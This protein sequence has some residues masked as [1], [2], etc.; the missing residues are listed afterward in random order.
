MKGVLTNTQRLRNKGEFALW[1]DLNTELPKLDYGARF[2]ALLIALLRLAFGCIDNR[3]TSKIVFIASLARGLASFLLRGHSSST[4]EKNKRIYANLFDGVC[5]YTFVRDRRLG[6]RSRNT[7]AKRSTIAPAV[8]VCRGPEFRGL[9]LT[10]GMPD[11]PMFCRRR[12]DGK[13]ESV[14]P[15][16]AWFWPRGH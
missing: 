13:W 9:R 14:E 2:L 16:L 3:D 1:T 6:C 15:K 7:R 12:S 8:S 10:E 4:N 5:E 11:T